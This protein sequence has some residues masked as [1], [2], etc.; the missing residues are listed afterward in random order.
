[1]TSSIRA[2]Y[3]GRR[4]LVTG[5]TG[6]VGRHVVAA[7][8][9]HGAEV[10]AVTRREQRAADHDLGEVVR[11]DLAVPGSAR[12]LVEQLR[13]AITFHLAGYGV[14]PAE[15]DAG[16]AE[17]LNH[18]VAAELASVC[19]EFVDASWS[20]QHLI[21]T[22]SALE[23]GTATGD[24]IESTIP[25]PTT[26]Y[27]TTKLAGTRAIQRVAGE[28][29]LRAVTARLFTVYGPGEHPGR[30]LPSLLRAAR[31]GTS[32]ELTDG[33]QRRDFTWVGDVVEVLLRLGLSGRPDIGIV[34][35]ATGALTTVRAFA[36]RAA[37]TLALPRSALRFG[38][39]PSRPSEMSHDAVNVDRLRAIAPPVPATP[40][41]TG[42]AWTRDAGSTR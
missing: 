29:T 8:R 7:L 13:P 41:E 28:G 39:L 31:D 33:S 9:E 17:R 10:H 27:G 2:T 16:L 30:L 6:F 40:I 5:A 3:A 1:M 22:G 26:Q 36:E 19:A 11:R 38:T 21:H 23:Y 12:A 32:L 34:N 25:T 35:T 42:V 14:D 20:G 37:D 4:V 24:L 18:E 15:R